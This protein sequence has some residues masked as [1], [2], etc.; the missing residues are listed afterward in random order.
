MITSKANP[1]VSEARKLLLKK[2]RDASGKYV[3][4]G[5]NCLSDMPRDAGPE[6]FFCTGRVQARAS[7]LAERHGVPIL[8]VSGEVMEALSGTESPA[9][10]L[11]VM[12]KPSP[13]PLSGD[14][15]VLDG[16]SD[17]GNAGTIVRTAVS[18][19][20]SDVVFA[21]SVDPWSPKT[22]RA[23]A[24]ALFRVNVIETA[25]E[26]LPAL[27]EGYEKICAD[28]GGENAFGLV[29]S[30]R[31]ALIVGG[32]AHG[33]SAVSRGMADVTASVPMSGGMESLNAAVAAGILMY[34]LKN[35]KNK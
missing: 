19:G 22:V 1:A 30:G 27:L 16:I 24:G 11:A 25:R 14:C 12:R 21:D 6:R 31:T 13:R 9:G 20:F 29:P 26:S 18:A 2:Y 17:P 10:I 5:F 3:A 34:V 7:A 15:V 4:E 32:E 28:A 23:A 33:L 8:T 35:N